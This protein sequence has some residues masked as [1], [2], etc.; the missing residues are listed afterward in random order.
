MCNFKDVT[1]KHLFY[2]IKHTFLGCHL[3]FICVQLF[4]TVLANHVL[5]NIF[6]LGSI[7]SKISLPNSHYR[8]IGGVSVVTSL[9]LFFWGG[10]GGGGVISCHF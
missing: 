5:I 7:V 9:F 6:E 3:V 8:N 1:T 2:A 4:R 10:G